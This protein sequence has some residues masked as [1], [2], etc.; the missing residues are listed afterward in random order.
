M[1]EPSPEKCFLCQGQFPVKEYRSHVDACLRLKSHPTQ[2]GLLSCV[3]SRAS[4]GTS[5]EH[6]FSQGHPTRSAD[7]TS[8]RHAS[9][10]SMKAV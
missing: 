6:A 3:W 10:T 8:Q 5:L 4:V 2:G 1:R 9:Y 7:G